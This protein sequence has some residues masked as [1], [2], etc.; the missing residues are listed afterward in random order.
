[1]LILLSTKW[2]CAREH[3]QNCGLI[4]IVVARLGREGC[5][6]RVFIFNITPSN[7]FDWDVD[8][9]PQYYM[10]ALCRLYHTIHH[11]AKKVFF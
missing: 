2:A 1:M 7:I 10:F 5:S 6:K 3:G 8:N 9:G 4:V 11:I